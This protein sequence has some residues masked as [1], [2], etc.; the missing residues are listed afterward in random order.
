MND[1][2]KYKKLEAKEL[3]RH[4]EPSMLG[5]ATTKELEPSL[6]II[7]QKRAV[8]S[9]D[10]GL[11]TRR[12]GYN[13]YVSGINGSGKTSFAID[14]AKKAAELGE[15]PN[16]LCYVYNFKEPKKPKLISVNAGIAINFKEDVEDII[17]YFLE[18]MPKIFSDKNY[19]GQRND[20]IRRF[21]KKRNDEMRIISKEAK[22]KNFEAKFNQKGM[23][24]A[25]I[26]D[27]KAISEEDYERLS[28][29]EKDSI[30]E[31]SD[32]IQEKAV[33]IMHNL[34]QFD[35]DVHNEVSQLEYKTALFAVG[36]K[37]SML[38]E[39]YEAQKDIIDY[40]NL[41]KEDILDNIDSFL[42]DYD[43]EDDENTANL[44]PWMSKKVKENVRA[45]YLINILAD[46]SKT[47]G[48]PVINAINP[49]FGNIMG[50]I[51]YDSEFGNLITD[52][53]NIKA[54]QLHEANGGYLILQAKDVLSV[55]HLWE[56]LKRTIKTKE[57]VIENLREY[58][59]SISVSSIKPEP[60][61]LDIKIILVGSSEYHE[62]L[63]NYDDDFSDLF[64]IIAFFDYEMDYNYQNI[65]DISHFIKRFVLQ[66]YLFDLNAEAVCAIIEYST[67]IAQSQKKLTARFDKISDVLTESYI[68]AKRA[69]VGIIEG[70]HV[71]QAIAQRE[72][73][74]GLYE[75]KMAELIENNVIMIDTL[76]NKVGQINGLAAIDTGDTV[77]AN[78]TKITAVTY[79]GKAGIVNIENEAQMSG[80]IHDKGV[81]IVIGYLGQKYATSFP[82][83][84]SC[85]VCFEQ[86]YNSIDGDSASSTELYSILSSL[87]EVPI[88]Q[89]IAVTGSINQF[90]EIQPVGAITEKIEGFFKLCKLRGLTGSQGVIIPH[91][92]MTDL[93][94]NIEV[95]E[96]VK[97]NQFHIYSISHID[98]GIELLMN[99]PAG[100]ILDCEEESGNI[101]DSVH[102]LVYK[103]LKRFHEISLEGGE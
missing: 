52:H 54:G 53:M 65:L 18:E 66:E 11:Y 64:K 37:I 20:I 14:F 97:N 62:I 103:K 24:F 73:R 82:L 35:I 47:V 85:R 83:S 8:A 79:V 71:N 34:R 99:K 42:I 22:E 6:N 84:L 16:D 75:A 55:P 87:A 23:Y 61:P 77:F 58:T 88:N 90:G 92:N 2:I 101:K 63:K 51:E 28:D 40:L 93:V 41:L 94:L 69:G 43:A 25:P 1:S 57:I 21:E 44:P 60:I 33:G 49:S 5:F 32:I 19:E 72:F 91:Q 38:F 4:C 31:S 12:Q 17:D 56:S 89:E 50:D 86:N 10:F 98:Q 102:G 80:E 27:G 9:F 13:I 15:T 46:N 74:F 81:Q 30:T 29:E 26:V 3:K 67:R 100:D 68:W 7:G 45:K 95:I 59:S 70:C 76:G 39:K 36:Q 78:P 48:C 96:S